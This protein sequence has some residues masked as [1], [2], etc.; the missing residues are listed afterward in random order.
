M[1]RPKKN[2]S[3]S[4]AQPKTNKEQEV[5][6][7]EVQIKENVEIEQE[8]PIEEKTVKIHNGE[9]IVV[10]D[11]AFKQF[12]TIDIKNA[13]GENIRI[14]EHFVIVIPLKREPKKIGIKNPIISLQMRAEYLPLNELL[15][16]EPRPQTKNIEVPKELEITLYF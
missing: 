5:I 2:K 4:N 14:P 11:K 8:Q 15:I 7:D 9:H 3:S 12:R 6:K 1:A 10:Y 13:S 16:L